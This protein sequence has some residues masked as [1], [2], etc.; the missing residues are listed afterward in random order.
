MANSPNPSYLAFLES[1]IAE[2]DRRHTPEEVA[3]AAEYL[4]RI[5]SPQVPLELFSA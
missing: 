2:A 4:A 5:P 3:A 1:C